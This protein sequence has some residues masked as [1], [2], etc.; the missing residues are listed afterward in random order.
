[1]SLLLCYLIVFLRD[2]QGMVADTL[3]VCQ[4]LGVDDACICLAGALLHTRHLLLSVIIS[5]IIDLLLIFRCLF[6]DFIFSALC[7]ITDIINGLQTHIPHSADLT[8]SL[9]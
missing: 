4:N 2:I 8:E 5:H 6:Q 3:E 1:M 7:K 9:L